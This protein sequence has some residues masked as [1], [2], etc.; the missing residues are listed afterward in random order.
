MPVH[1]GMEAVVAFAYQHQETGVHVHVPQ[2]KMA[3]TSHV[4]PEVR[5]FFSWFAPN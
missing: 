2:L 3:M 5:L 4:Y 1:L